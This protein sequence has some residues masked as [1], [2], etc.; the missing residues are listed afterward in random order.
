MFRDAVQFNQPLNSWDTSNVK[1][2]DSMFKGATE[3][4]QSLDT[5]DTS[6][7]KNKEEMFFGTKYY[8]PKPISAFDW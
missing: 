4:N 1:D 2:M 3:F 6:K 8:K 5:W 7:L